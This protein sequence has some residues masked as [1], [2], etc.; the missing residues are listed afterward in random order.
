MFIQ[1]IENLISNSVYWLKQQTDIEPDCSPAI[2]IT[3]RTKEKE[4]LFSDN[5]PGIDAADLEDVFRPFFTRKPAGKGKGLGLY[6]S[7]QI[8]EYHGAT[9]DLIA[10][11]DRHT[12]RYHTFILDLSG[13]KK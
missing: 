12:S 11:K 7:R 2:T 6:I 13:A 10:T 3:V 4:I 9:L 8:A 5:G 1:V